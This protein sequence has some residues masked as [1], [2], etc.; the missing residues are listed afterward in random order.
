[1]Q[2]VCYLRPTPSLSL[3]A[4]TRAFLAEC[5]RERFE[6]G[7]TYTE[8]SAEA[9]A[10]E[11]R[12]MLRELLGTAG[13]GQRGFAVVVIAALDVLG[14]TARE[15][16]RR[17]LQLEA[18][19]LPLRIAGGLDADAA[20]L[21]A[22][23]ERSSAERRREQVRSGMRDRALRGE[24]LGRAPYGYRVVNRHLRVHDAEAEV[25][26]EIFARYL[27]EGEGVRLIAAGLNERGIRTR[28]GGAWSIASVRAVLRN[29][30]YVGTYRRLGVVVPT[31]HE[32]VIDRERFMAAQELLS[33]RR[34]SF[35]R[36][37]RGEYLLT[38]LATCGYCGNRLIGARRASRA[39]VRPGAGSVLTY[40]QCESRANHGQCEYHT[41]R[42]AELEAAVRAQLKDAPAGSSRPPRRE[43]AWRDETAASHR[44]G[45]RRRLDTLLERRVRGE[46]TATR[47]REE[48]AWLALEDLQAEERADYE[49][50]WRSL[51]EEQADRQATLADV[52]T[53][54]AD[55]WDTLSFEERRRLLR[56]VVASITVTDDT[57]RVT[58]AG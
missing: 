28:R 54:L 14:S 33:E 11:F 45:L 36:Q 23:S 10:P 4:Q 53:R 49:E 8:T 50:R 25:V 47:L 43:H 31:E 15:Q 16:A 40:Y 9:G 55:R 39:R 13:A 34:T 3:E 42:A 29:A 17:Y 37:G 32:P 41:R 58:L 51:L 30:V 26:Q 12:R 22:W 44:E 1:M 5:E 2:A 48:A 24:V 46:W 52:R 35:T 7:P 57:L 20:L 6:V 38:G 18:L 56:Q 27:D 19:R 21:S